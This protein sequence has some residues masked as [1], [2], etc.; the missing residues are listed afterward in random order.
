[1]GWTCQDCNI[2]GEYRTPD[3]SKCGYAGPSN[4]FAESALVLCGVCGESSRSVENQLAS[5]EYVQLELGHYEPIER[6]LLT[7]EPLYPKVRVK[8]TKCAHKIWRDVDSVLC[9][10]CGKLEGSHYIHPPSQYFVPNECP[11]KK[12]CEGG[13]IYSGGCCLC[14]LTKHAW[15]RSGYDK[16]ACTHCKAR[17]HIVPRWLQVVMKVEEVRALQGVMQREHVEE[18]DLEFFTE[19]ALKEAGVDKAITRAKVL[20][21]I[22]EHFRGPSGSAAAGGKE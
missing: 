12:Y 20:R 10:I 21:C 13:W 16:Y 4:T 5:E 22:R 1:M 2:Q 17:Q 8:C 15:S 6:N 3:T 14:A 9:G 7:G 11:I 18:A 19:E